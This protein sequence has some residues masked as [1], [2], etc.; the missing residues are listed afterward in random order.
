[1]P[2][3]RHVAYQTDDSDYRLPTETTDYRLPTADYNEFV[4][5]IAVLEAVVIT[6]TCLRGASARSACKAT[7][8]R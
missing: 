1:M 2:A 8:F 5:G 6:V 4:Q 3:A 7:S